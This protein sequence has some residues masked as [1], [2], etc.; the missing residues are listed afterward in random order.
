MVFPLPVSPMMMVNGLSR[1]AVTMRSE[2]PRTG[3][4]A[5]LTL[6]SVIAGPWAGS[7]K[8]HY[9]LLEFFHILTDGKGKVQAH[10]SASEGCWPTSRAACL[11][12][13]DLT[14]GM[15]VLHQLGCPHC[16]AYLTPTTAFWTPL[17]K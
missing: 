8:P 17:N 1:T 7:Q 2:K 16:N 13:L 9:F 15:L 3:S 14:D 10:G 6:A 5:A 4:W 11:T 12:D